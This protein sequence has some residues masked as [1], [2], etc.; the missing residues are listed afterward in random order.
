[1]VDT[2][3]FETL[4]ATL[5]IASSAITGLQVEYQHYYAAHPGAIINVLDNAVGNF[6]YLSL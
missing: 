6:R 4:S 3:V 5:I 1:V 2:S